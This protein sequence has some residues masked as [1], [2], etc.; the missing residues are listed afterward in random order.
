MTKYWLCI[1]NE[2]NWKIIREQK[3]WGIPERYRGLIRKVQKGDFLVFY[4]S[5]KKITG[6]FQVASEPFEDWKEI[7]SHEGFEKKEIFPHRVRVEPVLLPEKP[8][9]FDHLIPKLKFIISK[10]KWM[11]YLRRA[12][13][14]IPKEDYD[15]ILSLIAKRKTASK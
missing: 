8:V 12:M 1:T 9:E 3:V 6:V 13:V 5:P 2:K 10:S 15:L 7:F 14:P 4:V 11:G